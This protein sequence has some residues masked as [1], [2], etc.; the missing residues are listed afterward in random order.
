MYDVNIQEPQK[1]PDYLQQMRKSI[2]FNVEFSRRAVRQKSFSL[3]F[4][5][6]S[7]GRECLAALDFA[8][9]MMHEVKDRGK[10]Y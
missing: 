1:N 8:K 10:V 4:V 5:G 2:T 9:G 6:R 7:W 3:L